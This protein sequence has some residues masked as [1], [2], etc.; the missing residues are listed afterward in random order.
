M[1]NLLFHHLRIRYIQCTAYLFAIQIVI[2]QK[3]M[4][5][6]HVIHLLDVFQ[7]VH[8]LHRYEIFPQM[9]T[10]HQGLISRI[11]LEFQKINII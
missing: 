4:H 8:K 5:S 1:R 7:D 10:T 2:L 3:H 11:V 9:I 6:Y